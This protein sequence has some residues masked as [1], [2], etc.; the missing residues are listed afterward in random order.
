MKNLN[1]IILTLLFL[2]CNGQEKKRLDTETKEKSKTTELPKGNWDVKKEF[3]EQGNLIKYDS[4]YSY[5][6]SNT[7][8]DSIKTNLDSIM[9]SFRSYF[10]LKSS[11]YKDYRFS[12]FPE[13]DSLF[14]QDFFKDDYFLNNW[15]RQPMQIDQML[16]KMDST[17][18]EFLKKFYPGLTKM[19]N[20]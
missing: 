4:M 17:R 16:K 12:Y 6:Y 20:N 13:N 5:T 8:G 14:M 7:M 2:G 9:R 18:N 11:L 1:A 15:E 19:E 10:E 3:D